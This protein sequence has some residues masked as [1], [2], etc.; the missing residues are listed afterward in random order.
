[1]PNQWS[2][3]LFSF[4]Y[5]IV[6]FLTLWLWS[7]LSFD[8]CFWCETRFEVYIFAYEYPI[9]LVPLIENC[10]LSFELLWKVNWQ[11]MCILFL[12]FLLYSSPYTSIHSV[13]IIVVLFINFAIRLCTSF[14]F[15]F[16][17]QNCFVTTTK[18]WVCLLFHEN[19]IINLWNKKSCWYF[20]MDCIESIDQL[21]K[22]W[23]CKNIESSDLWTWHLCLLKA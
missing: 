19:F 4:V 11:Y 22:I 16:L 10:L 5:V 8:F 23:Y 21:G 14:N 7:I 13:Q 6:L 1:M 20:D 9:V 12:D 15:V 2:H 3:F 17:F 18:N